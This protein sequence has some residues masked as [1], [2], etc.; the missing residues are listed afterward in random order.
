M[1]AMARTQTITT[2][3]GEELVVI[4]R[5]DYDA[6]VAAAD[7]GGVDEDA[8]DV[9]LFD[10][11]MAAGTEALPQGVAD[12]ILRGDSRLTAWRKHRGHSQVQLAALA[13]IS[14]SYLSQLENAQRDGDPETLAALAVA[15]DIAVEL[16][17]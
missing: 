8:E 3:G 4:T 12:R 13:G 14:Q 16:I 11:A 5:A 10:A 9:A 1:N 7:A 6:L 17:A 15:L 2:D